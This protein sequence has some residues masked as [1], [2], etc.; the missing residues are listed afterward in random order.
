MIA[1]FL[2]LEVGEAIRDRM[3]LGWGRPPSAEE[4]LMTKGR[5]LIKAATE[6]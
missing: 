3:L 6:K 2:L 5:A 4:I 1:T